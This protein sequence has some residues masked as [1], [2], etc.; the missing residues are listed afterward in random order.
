M[1][2]RMHWTALVIAACMA[3]TAAHAHPL[4]RYDIPAQPLPPALLE[5]ARAADVE[6]FLNGRPLM[7]RTSSAVHGSYSKEEALGRLLAGTGCSGTIV[8][9]EVLRISCGL[10]S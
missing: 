5:F 2:S 3:T 1:R 8:D 7:H 10:I 6:M 9:G 4:R